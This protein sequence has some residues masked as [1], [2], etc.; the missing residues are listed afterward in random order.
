MDVL[1]DGKELFPHSIGA[2]SMHTVRKR[3]MYWYIPPVTKITLK[4][5]PQSVYCFVPAKVVKKLKTAMNYIVSQF[6]DPVAKT[7]R[8]RKIGIN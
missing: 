7:L 8:D 6:H 5:D 1:F 4:K 3:F 2:Q